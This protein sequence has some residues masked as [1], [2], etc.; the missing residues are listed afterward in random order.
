MDPLLDT[1]PVCGGRR[2]KRNFSKKDYPLLGEDDDD[3]YV[4]RRSV[5]CFRWHYGTITGTKVK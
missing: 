5:C 1:N 4:V 2:F 3:R